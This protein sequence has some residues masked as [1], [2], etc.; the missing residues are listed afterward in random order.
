[1]ITWLDDGGYDMVVGPA[2]AAPALR[3]GAMTGR[4]YLATLRSSAARVPYTQA[5]NLAG[6]PALV[7]P[8]LIGG[9]PVGVQ[10]VG[11]PGSEAALLAAATRLEQRVVPMA[12]AAPRRSYA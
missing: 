7:A 10:L 12:G 5:W 4:G 1:M 2:V 6:L 11:R 9:Y 8:V 3:A